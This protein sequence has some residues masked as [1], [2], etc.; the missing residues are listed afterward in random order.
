M[1]ARPQVILLFAADVQC[2]QEAQCAVLVAH[3]HTA[4]LQGC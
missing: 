1:R 4:L 2:F 3:L